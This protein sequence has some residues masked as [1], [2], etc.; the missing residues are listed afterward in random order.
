[1]LHSELI[2]AK[3]KQERIE[4]TSIL[5]DDIH[6]ENCPAC[7][8]QVLEVD[9][10]DNCNLCGKHISSL[11]KSN[12]IND[13][14]LRMD[15]NNRID[16][17]ADSIKRREMQIQ[18]TKNVLETM[19][20]QKENFDNQLQEDLV[21]Y[22]S[23]I[24]EQIRHT[25]KLIATLEERISSFKKLQAMPQAIN[26]LEEEAGALQGI[27]DRLRSELINER[28]RLTDAD[29]SLKQ[30]AD[31]FK[32][33]MLSVQFPGIYKDDNLF[34]DPRNWKPTIVHNEQSWSFWDTG[35]GG[36]KTLF[37]VCYALAIHSIALKRNLPVPSIIIID[38][39]TKN[40]SD[41]ENPELVASLYK[42]IYQMAHE[43][44]PSMQFVLIDSDYV[45]PNIKLPDFIL[46][47][48]AGTKDAPSLI[49]YYDG[50]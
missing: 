26:K 24:I 16:E 5:F 10:V 43:S 19:C 23:A 25:D 41:D 46:R 15:M 28:E 30:I 22:D 13:E 21:N 4:S 17:L 35:S 39:P 11:N 18:K 20:V 14:S 37:N 9:L 48:M 29:I 44:Y 3:L 50:P 33:I 34:I 27:I 36:K 38:S 47:H 42:E 6:F 7:G 8:E 31:E 2:T 49:S 1:M 32:R 40:I 12:S 45:A